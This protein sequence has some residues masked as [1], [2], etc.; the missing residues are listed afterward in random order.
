[1]RISHFGRLFT[2]CA[3]AALLA[4]CGALRQAQEDTQPP[5][6]AQP[7][8][9]APGAMPQRVVGPNAVAEYVYVANGSALYSG[10]Y[11]SAYMI[12]ATSG[13]LTQLNRFK[14]GSGP[15]DVAVDPTGKFAYVTDYSFTHHV[16]SISAYTINA[17]SGALTQVAGSPFNAGTNAYGIATCRVK[18]RRCIPPPL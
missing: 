11:V 8:V 6:G 9:G 15:I 17:T 4:G 18:A 12:D 7:P 13:A 1:M 14:A 16:G 2:I 5:I 10:G 3:V